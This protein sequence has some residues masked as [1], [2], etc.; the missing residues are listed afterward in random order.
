[1]NLKVFVGMLY[2]FLGEGLPVYMS[3]A[4]IVRFFTAS[5]LRSVVVGAIL[6]YHS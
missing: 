1:M 3:P 4:L 6:S 5:F 2:V